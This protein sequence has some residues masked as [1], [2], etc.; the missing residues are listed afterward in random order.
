M[1]LFKNT[2]T[3]WFTRIKTETLIISFYTS[4]LLST[5]SEAFHRMKYIQHYADLEKNKLKESKKFNL[6]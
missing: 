3:C 1:C 4:F 5:F 2:K 6:F